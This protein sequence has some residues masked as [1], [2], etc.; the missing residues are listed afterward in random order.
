MSPFPTR[1]TYLSLIYYLETGMWE[2]A[3]PQLV[4]ERHWHGW[5]HFLQVCTRTYV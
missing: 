3:D 4:N 2:T 5:A 1:Y